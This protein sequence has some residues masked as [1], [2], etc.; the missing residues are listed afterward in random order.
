M[1]S[2]SLKE[3]L[4]KSERAYLVHL[5]AQYKGRI[6]RVAGEAKIDPKT[7]YRKLKRHGLRKEA[8]KQ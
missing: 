2:A 7:L 1:P 6:G 3:W 8:F 5:L 4:M